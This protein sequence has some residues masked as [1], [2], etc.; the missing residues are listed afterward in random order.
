L[1]KLSKERIIRALN[2][3]G[4]TQDDI[5]VYVL[6]AKTGSH[7]EREI[8]EMLGFHVRQTLR[9]LKNLQ[10]IEI[11]KAIGDYPL[12]YL[13]VPFEEVIDL[14]IEVKKEQAKT[15]QESR[16]GLLSSWKETIKKENAKS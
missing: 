13:A 6:L 3:L 9:S 10:E 8:S 12:Q 15:M 7:A 1:D 16:E 14:F 2:G 5:L 11:V 4:L